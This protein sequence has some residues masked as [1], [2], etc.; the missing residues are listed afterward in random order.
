MLYR[1]SSLDLFKSATF[2]LVSEAGESEREFRVR[3]AEQARERRDEAVAELRSAHKTKVERLEERIRK[4]KQVVEVQAEQVSQQRLRT[5]IHIGSTLLAAFTRR[6]YRESAGSALGGLGRSSKEKQDVRRAQES[7]D[8]L[9]EELEGLAA[10]LENQIEEFED[11][12]DPQAEKLTTQSVRP[13]KTDIEVRLLALAWC[14]YR[15]GGL[16]PAWY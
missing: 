16:E 3:L 11:R 8:V 5:A 10:E 15:R 6:S 1:G 2:G 13:R 14:P 4:A 12:F 9:S 7:L